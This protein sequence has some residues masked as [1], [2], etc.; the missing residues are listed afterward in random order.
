MNPK[1]RPNH[2]R[3]LEVLRSMTGEQRLLKALEMSAFT[4]AIFREG[5]RKRFPHLSEEEFHALFLERLALCHNK[6]Y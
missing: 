1:P 5:L 4:K 3:Y 6:N 2:Q